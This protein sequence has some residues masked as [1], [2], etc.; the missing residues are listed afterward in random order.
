MEITEIEQKIIDQSCDAV[1]RLWDIPVTTDRSSGVVS[2]GNDNVAM[3][4]LD[5]QGK[6]C[7]CNQ[8][9]ENLF[10]RFSNQMIGQPVSMLLPELVDPVLKPNGQPNPDLLHLSHS[11]L[12][13]D[14][15]PS[16]QLLFFF[17]ILGQFRAV[18][19]NGEQFLCELFLNIRNNDEHRQLS[20]YIRP[21]ESQGGSPWFEPWLNESEACSALRQ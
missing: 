9:S 20:L 3:L 5:E 17:R 14:G 18:S 8:A 6:V 21:A 4:K 1:N 13:N 2:G 19:A 15:Q 10:K 7:C 12:V 11:L 16:P